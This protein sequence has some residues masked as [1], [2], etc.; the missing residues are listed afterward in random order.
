MTKNQHYGSIRILLK[1]LKKI[2]SGFLSIKQFVAA[3]LRFFAVI[4]Y[5]LLSS[6]TSNVN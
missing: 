6:G 4:W 1:Y 3:D 5:Y 2:L